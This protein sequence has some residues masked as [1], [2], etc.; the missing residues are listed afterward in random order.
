ML[1]ADE[2]HDHL[3]NL[4]KPKGSLGQLEMLAAKLSL[5]QQTLKPRTKPR[6]IVIFAADHGVV[7]EGISAWPAEVTALMITNILSGGAASS[8]LAKSTKT[9]LRLVDVGSYGLPENESDNYRCVK[10]ACGTANL[11]KKPSMTKEQFKQA[12]LV[13]RAEAEIAVGKGA[14]ILAAGEMGIGNTTSASCITSLLCDAAPES[15]I[16][17]GAGADEVILSRKRD[18][19]YDAVQRLRNKSNNDFIEDISSICGFEIAAM[20][21]FYCKAFELKRV[22][23]IDGFISTAAALIAE[24][25]SPGCCG[26]MIA[27]HCSA[28]P[29]HKILL[30]KLKL[31]PLLNW[32]MHLGEGT[33]ALLAMP[34]IDA[35]ANI[36][37]KMATFESAGIKR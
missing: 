28:E 13:G 37:S 18:I 2:I 4:T 21:G 10:I 31:A 26:Y 12:A 20:A 9:E 35:A 1:T 32:S 36:T 34:L 17:S 5:C 24:K 8:V 14:R 6:S 27:S 7:T 11:S 19:V 22:M 30:K 16:G 3:N 15:V 23:I 33:G 25:I 29:G